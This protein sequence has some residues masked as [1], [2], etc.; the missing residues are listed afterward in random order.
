LG[1]LVPAAAGHNGSSLGASLTAGIASHG[2]CHASR[3]PYPMLTARMLPQAF[4]RKALR[5]SAA[6]LHW[7]LPWTTS[8][9][10]MLSS[11]CLAIHP[12]GPP[13]RKCIWMPVLS[14]TSCLLR[15]IHK[16]CQHQEQFQNVRSSG[17]CSGSAAGLVTIQSLPNAARLSSRGSPFSGRS[18]HA[19]S[20]QHDIQAV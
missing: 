1:C 12:A 4:W 7:R 19:C 3:L 20:G 18:A 6:G 13:R 17:S 9:Y 2:C 5:S 11:R 14:T 16:S 15:R 10:P 8:R